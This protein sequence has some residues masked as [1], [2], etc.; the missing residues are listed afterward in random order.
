MLG[1]REHERLD[2][3]HQ[4]VRVFGGE[5]VR[6]ADGGQTVSVFG[7]LYAGIGLDV[8]PRSVRRTRRRHRRAGLTGVSAGRT[9]ARAGGPAAATK[10]ATRSPTGRASLTAADLAVYFIDARTGAV[11]LRY[12]DLQTT[13]GTGRA[14]S[15]TPRRSA[16]RCAIGHVPGL[17]RH[18]PAS[19]PHLRHEGQPRPARSGS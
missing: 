7:A 8:E 14:C 15:A 9:H 1:G 3:Y 19:H 18:A 4:G 12:S 11:V 2:Q 5:L 6:Q 10:A 17:G 16:R 13:I